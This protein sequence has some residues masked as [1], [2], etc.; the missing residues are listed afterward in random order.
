MVHDKLTVDLPQTG[1]MLVTGANGSGKSALIEAIAN[2]AWGK[3]LR[4]RWEPWRQ[5]PGSVSLS[6]N[7]VEIERVWTGKKKKLSWC[8]PGQEP[9][10]FESTTKAQEA[11]ESI[12]GDFGTW[13][14]TTVFS[15]SDASTFS[16]ATDADR[17][18]LLE[19]ILGLS[20]F[21]PA[22]AACRQDLKA[23]QRTLDGISSEYAIL[24]ERLKSR[25]EIANT[26]K[27][28]AKELSEVDELPELEHELAELQKLKRSLG[29]EIKVVQSELDAIQ[30]MA[31]KHETKRSLIEARLEKL[32]KEV[33]D[34]CGQS[35]SEKLHKSM[36]L[37]LG[38]EIETAELER[39]R[40]MKDLVTVAPKH[41]ELTAKYSDAKQKISEREQKVSTLRS[42]RSQYE[43]QKLTV[44]TERKRIG[45]IRNKLLDLEEKKSELEIDAAELH[46]CE[47]I[48][49]LKGIRAQVLGRALHGVESVANSW[50]SRFSDGRMSVQ[51]R[52]DSDAILLEVSGAGGGHGYNGASGGERRRVD[53]AILMGLAEVASSTIS[54]ARSPLYF[55][56]V[57][58]AL[59]EQ[60]IE[61]VTEALFE[62]GKHR[63]VMV[64]S[65][66]H[67]KQL[68]Q[69]AAK[70]LHLEKP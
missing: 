4:S 29:D 22:L 62:M 52:D 66:R 27:D 48:L 17:K 10:Q 37:V 20:W 45:E 26:A 64:I 19:V 25:Q 8:L 30:A 61:M 43:K 33:C 38:K 31:R 35:V 55:D 59:D 41:D 34:T 5:Q 23:A 67:T 68:K 50:L 65:H 11:L 57:F 21:D 39:E 54:D 63:Q 36:R 42:L 60:G 53:V 28:S 51:L 56:E 2:C 14:R 12:V 44:E 47:E 7:V 1:V 18:R 6:S 58:D 24:I 32:P 49:G 15:S 16:G 69:I 13:R 40:A 9:T 3:S 70:Y 46:T